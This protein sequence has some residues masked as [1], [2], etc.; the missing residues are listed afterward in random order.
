MGKSLIVALAVVFAGVGGYL[1][2]ATGNETHARATPRRNAP[3]EA[4]REPRAATPD[5]SAPAAEAAATPSAPAPT[6]EAAATVEAALRRFLGEPPTARHIEIALER[7]RRSREGLRRAAEQAEMSVARALAEEI[8]KERA[9]LEDQSRGGTMEMLRALRE[10]R[11]RPFALLEDRDSFG[12][13]FTRQT[14]GPVI[15]GTT[16]KPSDPI[17]D[18][19]TLSF[20]AGAH[21]FKSS[22]LDHVDRFPK[23]LLI[24][25]AGMD[26]TLVRL[27][28][29][30][31]RKEIFSLTFRDL[32]IDCGNDYLTDLRRD[33]PVTIRLERCRV[34]RFDMG[35]GGSVMLAARV[36]AF[37][38]TDCRFEAGYGRYPG[39]GN[40]FRTSSGL[41]RLEH[42][43]IRGPFRSVFD[44]AATYVFDR[45]EFHGTPDYA[46]SPP[47]HVRFLECRFG[48]PAK[49]ER[50]PRPLAELNPAW[51]D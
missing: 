32:T 22:A 11:V 34:V 36:A 20:P 19:T 27:D 24:L 38:A 23:D 6:A 9:F 48:P 21:V 15:V 39:S 7:A 43:V 40:L 5:P 35:A 12:A 26:A 49:A 42:C 10:S 16:W 45:C 18:G 37:F 30:G 1:L 3:V 47:D 46:K 41:V 51:G 25:G 28:E 31:T 33:E 44:R 50:K 29:I 2:G 8:K 17:P 14:S 4:P 13:H